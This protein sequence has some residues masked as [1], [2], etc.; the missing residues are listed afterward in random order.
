MAQSALVAQLDVRPTGIFEHLQNV[1]AFTTVPLTPLQKTFFAWH[2]IL[3]LVML[4]LDIPCFAN[5]VDPDQL[6]SE[7]AN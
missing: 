1:H 4:N 2:F 3:T 6:A 5:S 7:E